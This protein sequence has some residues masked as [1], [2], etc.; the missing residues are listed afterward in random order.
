MVNNSATE[1]FI[2]EQT[3]PFVKA[4]ARSQERPLAMAQPSVIIASSGMLNGG[5]SV[6]Y[7]KPLLER[8]NAAIFISGYCDE[9]SPGRLLQNLKTDD[10]VELDG[11]D[12]TVRAQIKRFNLSAHA[13]KL[14]L[15]QVIAK[16]NPRHLILVHGSLDAL[17]ELARTGD[18][19]DK[20]YVHIP[21]VGEKIEYGCKLQQR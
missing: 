20:H 21:Q 14:G 17:H 4:I 9:E 5:A 19:R 2:D 7:A 6:Y 11:Q 16:V 1:P 18:L 13:D 3:K 8:N 12:V 15:T 10:V